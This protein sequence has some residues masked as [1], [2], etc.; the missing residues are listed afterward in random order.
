MAALLSFFGGV[1]V[2][3]VIAWA[4]EW[5]HRHFEAR[6]RQYVARIRGTKVPELVM[7]PEEVPL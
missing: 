7:W 5:S 6:R 3:A 4:G 1:L 2:C